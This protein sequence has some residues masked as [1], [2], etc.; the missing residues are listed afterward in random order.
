MRDRVMVMRLV[1]F[2]KRELKSQPRGN[3]GIRVQNQGYRK[4]TY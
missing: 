1:V 3:F 2:R 4:R